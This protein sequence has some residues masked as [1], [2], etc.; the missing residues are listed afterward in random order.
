MITTRCLLWGHLLLPFVWEILF[1]KCNIQIHSQQLKWSAQYLSP[2]PKSCSA[3]LWGC[4]VGRSVQASLLLARSLARSRHV[5][6]KT[7]R[8]SLGGIRITQ[9]HF[10]VSEC[11]WVFFFFFFCWES[12]ILERGHLYSFFVFCSPGWSR[13]GFWG[14][15]A[16][17]LRRP[18]PEHISTKHSNI[19]R[20]HSLCVNHP[21]D[22][23]IMIILI[24]Y[25]FSSWLDLLQIKICC[26]RFNCFPPKK[27]GPTRTPVPRGIPTCLQIFHKCWTNRNASCK[28][29]IHVG[30]L[31]PT[32][33]HLECELVITLRSTSYWPCCP[34]VVYRAVLKPTTRGSIWDIF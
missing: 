31:V 20:G 29:H 22:K 15:S 6:F 9:G 23:P 2:G 8:E 7:W 24:S 30:S 16:P 11:W 26:L 17:S 21:A 27:S 32:C 33:R 13:C 5:I 34:S 10:P 19:T 25:C 1:K 4:V 12:L 3:L 14:L 18:V 28:A